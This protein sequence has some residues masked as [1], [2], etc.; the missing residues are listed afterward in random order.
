MTLDVAVLD[1]VV[2]IREPWLT[3]AVAV[4][5]RTGGGVATS[6]IAA[7]VALL[8][9]RAG[10]LR[11]A[12]FVAGAVFTGWPVM[13]L[14]KHLFGRVRPPEP[15]RLLALQTESF[16][17]G[18]AMTSAI[19]A[20]VLVAVVVRTWPRGDRR[21]TVATAALATYTLAIGLSRV[22]LAAHWLTDVAAG[23]IFGIAW[24]LGWVWFVTRVRIRR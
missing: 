20:T 17:S 5:T 2:S 15:E 13:T 23:W 8:L 11:D 24:A 22:Y 19:L 1:W 4:F 14:L 21:R 16:P 6:L 18:H 12:V 10:R 7:V 3:D 9:V